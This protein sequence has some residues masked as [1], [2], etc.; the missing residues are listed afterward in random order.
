VPTQG[1]SLVEAI[2]G[3]RFL[4]CLPHA[5]VC[6]LCP[7]EVMNQESDDFPVNPSANERAPERPSRPL[8]SPHDERLARLRELRQKQRQFGSPSI[9]PPEEFKPRGLPT[10]PPEQ[11]SFQEL[12][13]HWWQHGPLGG[14][15]SG[16]KKPADPQAKNGRAEPPVPTL[17]TPYEERAKEL[18]AQGRKS[19]SLATAKAQA[20][21]NQAKDKLNQRTSSQ[22]QL[23]AQHPA[24]GQPPISSQP[25]GPNQYP[26]SGPLPVSPQY[27]VSG[28]LPAQQPIS[29]QLPVQPRNSGQLPT[30]P[31]GAGEI[32]PGMILIGFEM[33]VP[34]DDA[35]KALVALGCRPMRHK[36]SRNLFQVAVPPGYE[37]A[38]M[39]Q[40]LLLPGVISADLE[41]QRPPRP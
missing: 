1:C 13:K 18:L 29:G 15:P 9:I 32:V 41:R 10:P 30:Q 17:P 23:S 20:M 36:A 11:P 39:Q 22:P 4:V 37:L 5:A 26:V 24:S 21:M 7:V 28:Q 14:L 38:L 31:S 12:V 33:T 35:I 8:L 34:R 3:R 2:R 27:P 40:I 6:C 19:L 25:S 16:Y